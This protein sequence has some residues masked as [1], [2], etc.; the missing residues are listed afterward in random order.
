MR[1]HPTFIALFPIA[2]LFGCAAVQDE[3]PDAM[4]VQEP[5]PAEVANPMASFARMV[6]GEWRVTFANGTSQFDTWHWGPGEHSMRALTE[7]SNADGTS[8]SGVCRVLYWHP[9]RKEIVLLGLFSRCRLAQGTVKIDG[10]VVDFNSDF[11]DLG[12][13]G[14]RR[15]LSLRWAFDGPDKYRATLNE[16]TAAA[17]GFLAEWDYVRSRPPVATR[18]RTGEETSKP[19][20]R[21]K[22]LEALVGH[23]WEARGDWATGDAFHIQSTF[24]WIPYV[25]ATYAR[26]F[27]LTQDGEPTHLLD[28]YIYDHTG[29]DALHCLALSNWGG[30]YEGDLTVLEGG[31]LQLDLKGYEGDQVVPHV[32][33]FDFEQDGT[34]RDRV[35][36]LEGTG[37]TLM[38]DVHHKKL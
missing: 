24:E 29:T 4:P 37:P 38:L 5:A 33:R 8:T 22:A 30:V 16:A 25:D 32:V 23:T 2:G 21:L 19:S 7:S 26:A 27:A 3:S 20:E 11:H 15:E 35:W 18:P 31:A 6:S 1:L 9:G 28:A 17:P 14:L 10:E 34:L 13:P 36:S 12:L